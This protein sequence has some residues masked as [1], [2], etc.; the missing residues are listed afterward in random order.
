[1]VPL[2]LLTDWP[3]QLKSS[4]AA[5]FTCK[6]CLKTKAEAMSHSSRLLSG[7]IS[8]CTTPSIQKDK[9]ALDLNFELN[10]TEKH[11]FKFPT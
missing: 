7:A 1:V 4:T 11:F 9:K 6:L 2:S 5:D 3:L 10:V 8:F